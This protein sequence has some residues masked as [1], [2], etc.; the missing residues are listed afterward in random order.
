MGVDEIFQLALD[1]EKPQIISELIEF[2]DFL[3]G[4]KQIHSLIDLSCKKYENNEYN[5]AC[6]EIIGYLFEIKIPFYK[7]VNQYQQSAWMLSIQNEN[8]YVFKKL[9][10]TNEN[11]NHVDYFNCTPLNYAIDKGNLSYVNTLLKKRAN[12]NIKDKNGNNALIQAVQK[13]DFEIVNSLIPH[14]VNLNEFDSNNETALNASVRQK[15]MKIATALI[16]AGAEISFNPYVDIQQETIYEI[17][18]DGK[19]DHL[20]YQY[21]TQIDGFI[22]LSR[23]GFNLN[24]KNADGDYFL[25]HFIKNGDFSNFKSFLHCQVN[26]NLTNDDNE[27]IIM[28]AAKKSNIKYFSILLSRFKNFDFN[29]KNN[30]GVSVVDI[31]IQ[32]N[33]LPK[34]DMLLDRLPNLN[35]ENLGKSLCY[36]ARYGK[37]ERH[38][39]YFSSFINI[40]SYCDPY[41]NNLLMHSIAGGNLSNFEYILNKI[42]RS[43][44]LL[45]NKQNKN[46]YDLVESIP[47]PNAQYEFKQILNTYLKKSVAHKIEKH[48][49]NINKLAQ[50]NVLDF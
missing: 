33:S 20:T 15:R 12:P 16:W 19:T 31:C 50:T 6:G 47:N 26:P 23:L 30:D 44:L 41:S 22:A 2:A 27:T 39:E 32:T 9:A 46:I 25:H 14:I 13:G 5:K 24:A 7:F 4:E 48:D 36:I 34:M 21:D 45:K 10:Q 3:P 35:N 1:F 42:D 29:Q 43:V 38:A 11:V 8:D 18:S 28:T 40:H 17:T 37:F 49:V